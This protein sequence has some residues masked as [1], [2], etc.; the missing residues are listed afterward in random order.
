MKQFKIKASYNT[1]PA[2]I[3]SNI[4]ANSKHSNRHELYPNEDHE[5]EQQGQN[6]TAYRFECLR[7]YLAKFGKNYYW[8][9]RLSNRWV[10]SYKIYN[11]YL[12]F[13]K[14]KNG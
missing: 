5:I 4:V 12:N 6:N 13:L 7:S 10:R 14:I 1:N 2:I 3:T 9:E 8:K 11:C